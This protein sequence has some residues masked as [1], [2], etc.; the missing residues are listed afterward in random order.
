MCYC[1]EATVQLSPQRELIGC[2]LNANLSAAEDARGVPHAVRAALHVISVDW[3][4][5][6]NR[7]PMSGGQTPASHALHGRLD[8]VLAGPTLGANLACSYRSQSGG[9]AMETRLPAVMSL[10]PNV[11]LVLRVAARFVKQIVRQLALGAGRTIG[12]DAHGIDQRALCKRAG[13]KVKDHRHLFR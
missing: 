1:R 6:A 12:M 11:G 5:R 2:R 10:K 8:Q 13:R 9:D 3:F 4:I 7:A